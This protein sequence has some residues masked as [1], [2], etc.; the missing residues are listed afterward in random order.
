MSGADFV[1]ADVET[2]MD[3]FLR[4]H[5]FVFAKSGD[6][7]SSRYA[8][9]RNGKVLITFL[10][11]ILDGDTVRIAADPGKLGSIHDAVLKS[12]DAWH[13]MP[14]FSKSYV[15]QAK[16]LS[17]PDRP[18]DADAWRHVELS[19]RTV[20][21]QISSGKVQLALTGASWG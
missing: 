16:Q 15:A 14:D 2:Y 3:S 20:L 9:Y 5:S 7:G 1:Q 11:S 19:L 18:S 17:Y 6:D 4:E 12:A 8:A 10:W 13:Y 21:D